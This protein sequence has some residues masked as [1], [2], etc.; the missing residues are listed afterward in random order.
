MIVVLFEKYGAVS[1][2]AYPGSVSLSNS[3]ELSQYLSKL[4][5]QDA[6]ILYE[7]IVAGADDKV[8]QAKKG[9]LLQGVPN[10][11]AINLGSPPCT[12][13]LVYRN[14]DNNYHSDK[15]ITPQEFPKKYIG[16]DLSE[17]IPVIS[18]PAADEPYGKSYTVEMLG[19]AAGSR[20]VRYLNLDMERSK[21]LAIAQM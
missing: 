8:A 6:Q 7:A 12:I 15:S 16:L 2:A 21:E 20:D 13:D 11:L 1:E 3:R 17:Y 19:N 9:A 5:Y 10:F 18:A 4:L 14:E